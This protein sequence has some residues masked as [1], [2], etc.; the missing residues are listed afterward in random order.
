MRRIGVTLRTKATWWE[1]RQAPSDFPDRI[2]GEGITAYALDQAM[3]MRGI[4]QR[5]DTMWKAGLEKLEDSGGAEGADS[6]DIDDP[7]LL[8]WEV[9]FGDLG[10]QGQEEGELL[11]L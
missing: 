6:E 1:A 7:P 5:F 8:Q 3:I 10:A 2:H 9:D 4:A 11:G